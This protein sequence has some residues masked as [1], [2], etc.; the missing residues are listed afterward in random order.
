MLDFASVIGLCSFLAINCF[1]KGLPSLDP[2]KAIIVIEKY[3]KFGWASVGNAFLFVD[4]NNNLNARSKT[5]IIKE[6]LLIK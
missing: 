5:I 4:D 3:K 2:A 1:C 6:Y